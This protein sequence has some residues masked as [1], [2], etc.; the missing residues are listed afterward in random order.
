MNY[1]KKITQTI[2][3]LI[4][5]MI[6]FVVVFFAYVILTIENPHARMGI[7]RK[8]QS[9]YQNDAYIGYT[10]KPNLAA[11]LP[12]TPDTAYAVF[13]DVRGVRVATAGESSSA[14]PQVVVIGDSQS[15]GMGVPNNQ[16]YPFALS[17]ELGVPVANLGVPGYGTV[18][19][20][21]RLEKFG[22]YHPKVIVLGHY[23]D[24]TRRNINTCS[25]AFAVFNC[26]TVPYLAKAQNNTF[27]VREPRDNQFALHQIASYFDYVTGQGPAYN[28]WL[29]YFW[30]GLRRTR[31][32]FETLRLIDF[33]PY[34][35]PVDSGVAEATTR[36]LFERL[37]NQA[38]AIGARPVVLYIPDYLGTE[39]IP[40]P[41]YI[42]RIARDLDIPLVDA[43]EEIRNIKERDP[44]HLSVPNDGHLQEVPHRR[45]AMLL[46]SRI[47]NLGLLN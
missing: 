35:E 11:D 33:Y 12:I 47:R 24:H 36:I 16:T 7:Q 15:F 26:I 14:I 13:T 9:I 44:T 39:V 22:D 31:D 6:I 38:M 8:I 20:L 17:Q 29:D 25:P 45:I 1:R 40:A 19:A 30:W 10:I 2:I 3:L 23:Y 28:W 46:A 37:R 43:T 18:A 34:K 41:D 32:I 42:A 5:N 21:R 4:I 27:V